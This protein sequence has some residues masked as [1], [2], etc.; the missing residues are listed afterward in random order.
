[1]AETTIDERQAAKWAQEDTLR[2]LLREASLNNSILEQYVKSKLG[3]EELDALKQ[4]VEATRDVSS[5][6]TTGLRD[7]GVRYDKTLK[8]AYRD[9][10]QS[11]SDS[12]KDLSRTMRDLGRDG[13][14]NMLQDASNNAG[15]SLMK[16]SQGLSGFSRTLSMAGAG[17][18]TFAT[19]IIQGWDIVSDLNDNYL[20]MYENGV[21]F[22]QGLRGMT[23]ATGDLG[24]TTDQLVS[25]F[26]QYSA[27]VATLGTDRAV[28]LGK[29]FVRLN[30]GMG[31][32]GL[33]N[34]QA[35]EAVL[36]YTELIR[37]TGQ[38]SRMTNR[39][40][41]EGTREYY[42]ELNQ[43]TAITGQNRREMQKS[44]EARAKEASYQVL[45]RSLPEEIQENITKAMI[46]LER[47]GPAGAQAAQKTVVA[48]L[49]R[50]GVSGL[51]PALR[52][53]LNQ[54]GLI[55]T[56]ELLSQKAKAGADITD[57]MGIIAERLG[58]PA[59]FKSFQ[60]FADMPGPVG[61]MIR[62]LADLAASTQNLRNDQE[63]LRQEAYEL[64][65]AE[66]IA[67][68]TSLTG[69]MIDRHINEL[70]KKRDDEA[71]ARN[72]LETQ[73]QNT[74]S[75]ASAK[76]TEVFNTLV[77]DVMQ[78]LIPA[79]NLFGEIIIKL[80]NG[81]KM[82][83]D[84]IGGMFRL[85]GF[86]LGKPATVNAEGEEVTP[87][88]T[89]WTD[90]AGAVGAAGL[91]IAGGMF[92]KR[93]I[94]DRLFRRK[95]GAGGAGREPGVESPGI[96]GVDTGALAVG[97]ETI[98]QTGPGL[99]AG[100]QGAAAGLKAFAAPQILVGAGILAGSITVIGAGVAG[101]TWI[102]GKALPSLA[103]GL[104]SFTEI[105]GSKL[106]EVGNGMIKIGGGLIAMGVGEVA[107]AWGS[108]ASGITS[109]FQADPISKLSRFAEISGPLAEAADSMERF[110]RVYPN[111]INM[112]ND[113]EISSSAVDAM[114]QVKSMLSSDMGT[115]FGGEPPI[116]GQITALAKS[117]SNLAQTANQLNMSTQTVE[118]GTIDISSKTLEFYTDSKNSYRSM[119]ELL[120]MAND[121]L[122]QLNRAT[123]DQTAGV[124]RTIKKSGTVWG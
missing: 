66:A 20:K 70:K 43:I 28:R 114:E 82:L 39:E 14:L 110:G 24:I 112:L 96:P 31:E 27:A 63:A 90:T 72:K 93:R 6:T 56:F 120:Q 8:E 78:P 115:L 89:D 9:L 67:S 40:L 47:L 80:A 62:S 23:Q 84:L 81:F 85:T 74:L 44:I 10:D 108:I 41:I 71:A 65:R 122:E 13:L 75:Q 33:T 3:K 91:T 64:A 42:T 94:V 48:M 121:K 83:T 61:D 12:F 37:S 7:L 29:E 53:A 79:L 25:V 15:K 38:L 5:T 11:L 69:E 88:E 54:T 97:M 57:E 58:D 117:I 32:L 49:A 92:A 50:G 1:M 4:N 26:T 52:Q 45:L 98:G 76:L 68:N 102:M 104:K 2:R 55:G 73:A 124:T 100:L 113:I 19:L 105:D 51:D 86:G 95:T 123:V 116:I 18:A 30:R 107:S 111:A 119:I 101:A 17:L 106:G 77:V 87:R 22:T 60:A 103:E 21:N 59:V 46:S 16:T 118:A 36:E 35:A 34:A 99:G 109:L